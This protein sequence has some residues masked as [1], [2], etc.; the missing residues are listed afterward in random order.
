MHPLFIAPLLKI[1]K[2]W[3]RCGRPLMEKLVKKTWYIHT[4]EFYAAATTKKNEILPSETIWMDP[5]S[6]MLSKMSQTGK[7]K[8]C[9]ISLLCG[10]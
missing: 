9:T 3:N 10:I 8:Y 4:V 2:I 1:A 6:I 7:H 5:E